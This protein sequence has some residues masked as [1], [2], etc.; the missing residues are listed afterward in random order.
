M[1]LRSEHIEFNSQDFVLKGVLHLPVKSNPPLVVGSHGLEGSK[2]SAKQKVLSRILPENDIAFF[3]FDH[4]GCGQSSGDFLTETSLEKRSTDF[5]NAVKQVI[6]LKKTSSKLAL[7]GS[8]LGGSTCIHAWEPILNLDIEL[9]GAVFC[10]APVKSRNIVNIPIEATDK[11]PALPIRFFADNLI[12]NLNGKTDLIK[13][14]LLF[15]GDKDEVVPVE[16]AHEIYKN[17]Q[18][19]K[20][21]IIHKG[22]DHQMTSVQDQLQFE[23]ETLKWFIKAFK[24]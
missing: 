19:P 20:K 12:F 9:C 5:V 18:P 13:N 14:L 8:S 15:H 22:G 24:G 10:S 7:F 6:S 11:R 3:R 2:E 17:V 16:S 21:I 1:K 4:R 23:Q